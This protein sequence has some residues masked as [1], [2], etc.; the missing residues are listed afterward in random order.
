M[1]EIGMLVDVAHASD[2]TCLHAIE[3]SQVPLTI[4]HRG[5]RALWPT[6][7]R[8]QNSHTVRELVFSVIVSLLAGIH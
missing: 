3:H 4:S 2:Q 7:V 8:C 6:P 5:A 1:N